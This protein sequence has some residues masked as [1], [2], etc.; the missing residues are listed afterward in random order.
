MDGA[1]G[2]L[3]P[4]RPPMETGS[5]DIPNLPPRARAWSPTALL[6]ETDPRDRRSVIIFAAVVLLAVILRVGTWDPVADGARGRF[7][8]TAVLGAVAAGTVW[9]L[10]RV[11]SR[12]GSPVPLVCALLV[13]FTGDAVHY[14]RLTNPITR[15]APVVSL[16]TA[17]TD[18]A[19]ARRG[20]DL[21]TAGGGRIA[22]EGGALRLESPP[23]GSAYVI[24]RLPE[25]PDVLKTWWLPVG[26]MDRERSERVTWRAGVQRTGGF[27]AVVEIRR[28]LVQVVSYGLHVTYPDQNNTQ[29]GTEINHPIG[30]DGQPHDWRLTRARGEITLDLDGRQVWKA[31]EREAINQVRL[32]DSKTDPAHGGVMRLERASYA[33][34]LIRD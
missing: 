18:E 13:L 16:D 3:P 15:G 1:D 9:L 34:S 10:V 20:W 30:T 22:A 25:P 17:F 21:E 27:Y 11:Q 8:K 2:T 23:G 7:A 6:A 33:S 5:P 29:R 12:P 28:L 26:L 14:L 31:P 24:A 19:A 4:P 32:G